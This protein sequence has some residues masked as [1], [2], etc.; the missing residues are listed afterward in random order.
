MCRNF[1]QAQFPDVAETKTSCRRHRHG[2]GST[3]PERHMQRCIH[4]RLSI[5]NHALLR[6]LNHTRKH[7]LPRLTACSRSFS[8]NAPVN[9]DI[10]FGHYSIILPPEKEPHFSQNQV[11]LIIPRPYYVA[12]GK[13]KTGLSGRLVL[14]SDAEGKLRK[15]CLLAKDTLN[16]AGSLVKVSPPLP[17]VSSVSTQ[18][19]R[20]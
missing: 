14:G 13:Q 8:Q 16:F 15:S 3:Q 12:S 1:E 19:R 5:D 18:C 7:I 4:P 17:C 2:A 10:D 20:G 9:S 6:Q 11:P